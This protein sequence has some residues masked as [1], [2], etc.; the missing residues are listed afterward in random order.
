LARDDDGWHW[1]TE[2]SW[3]SSVVHGGARLLIEQNDALPRTSREAPIELD[4]GTV[5]AVN[6]QAP[7]DLIVPA[8]DETARRM[9]EHVGSLIPEGAAVQYGPG[10]IGDAMLD[11]LTVPVAVRSGMVTDAVVRLTERG[12]LVDDPVAAYVAG[13]PALY[14]WADGRHITTAV[15][16]THD[17]SVADGRPFITVNSAIEVDLAGQV[18][19]QAAGGR[20]V[21]GL[22]GHPDFAL[23]G[24]RSIGGLSIIAMTTSRGGRSTLV[25]T[26]SAPASTA[27]SDV[28]LVVTEHGVADLRGLDDEERGLELQRIWSHS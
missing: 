23:A 17:V 1:G 11:S 9:G 16:R 5:V 14:D 6:S 18:N 7:T 8:V 19:V 13:S 15:Q 28:D 24:H 2:V 10:A 21:S 22:G 4:R 25:E 26:L 3:M 27:R 12:L 20:H